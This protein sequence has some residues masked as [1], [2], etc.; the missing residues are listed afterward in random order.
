MN[1]Q[2]DRYNIDLSDRSKY[3]PMVI[4]PKEEGTETMGHVHFREAHEH[5]NAGYYKLIPY[6]PKKSP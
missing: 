3:I 5:E 4:C 2:T 1:K 6:K